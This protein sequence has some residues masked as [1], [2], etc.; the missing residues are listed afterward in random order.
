MVGLLIHAIIL[1]F[2]GIILCWLL[3]NESLKKDESEPEEQT[4]INHQYL[5]LSKIKDI[6][7]QPG[8]S[9]SDLKQ[10]EDRLI[11]DIGIPENKLE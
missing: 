7:C 3:V 1:I 5:D 9:E 11:D 6:E 2:L 8:F 10:L 4:T